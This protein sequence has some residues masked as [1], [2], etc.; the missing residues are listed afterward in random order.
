MENKKRSDTAKDS[1][2]K[3]KIYDTLLSYIDIDPNK[4]P[5]K[6]VELFELD[7]TA[8]DIGLQIKTIFNQ[9]HYL[10]KESG[11]VIFVDGK[12]IIFRNETRLIHTDT[13]RTLTAGEKRRFTIQTTFNTFSSL[14][15][16]IRSQHYAIDHMKIDQET[17]LALVEELLCLANDIKT[18]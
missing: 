17:M 18:E 11:R 7:I 12:V 2:S 4:L 13:S 5:P 1:T 8:P 15:D 6:F 10:H 14:Y 3:R 16:A 9:A